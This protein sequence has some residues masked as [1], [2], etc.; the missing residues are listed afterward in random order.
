MPPVDFEENEYGETVPV[1]LVD[2]VQ[3]ELDEKGSVDLKLR[4]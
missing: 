1:G 3:R 2:L 4:D